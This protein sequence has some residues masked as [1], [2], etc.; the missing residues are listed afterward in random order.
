MIVAMARSQ[1]IAR[2]RD[3]EVNRQRI[4]TAA[5]EVFCSEG[6]SASLA[7]IA[8]RAGVGNATLHRNFAGKEQ[9]L[10]ELFEQIYADRLAR[11]EKANA[12]PDPWHGLV[13]FM[14]DT[15]EE[16]LCDRAAGELMLTHLTDDR[17]LV[18]V[19]QQLM[20]RAQA[21]GVL[22]SDVTVADLG[23]LVLGIRNTIELTAERSPNQWRRHM[24]V[25]LA[26]LQDREGTP[27]PGRAIGI[28]Q[29][30]QAVR[31]WNQTRI[32]S[33]A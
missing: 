26:G 18:K 10:D 21:A 29:F 9:L 1:P 17:R 30:R 2:R 23:L 25:V 3:A 15:L 7:E 33:R 20:G 28:D 22:R 13:S 14:E 19:V 27:L 24:A 16:A 5:A 12:D 31:A 4:L 6:V 32:S 8:R 11:A